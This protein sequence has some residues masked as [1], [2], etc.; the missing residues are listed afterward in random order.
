MRMRRPG[1]SDPE[2]FDPHELEIARSVAADAAGQIAE[3]IWRV[4]ASHQDS[5]ITGLVN[6]VN[7][8][9]CMIAL[10]RCAVP[11]IA[12]STDCFGWN[13]A[14][15]WFCDETR[16]SVERYMDAQESK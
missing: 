9:A 11:L 4:M 12:A 16:A 7:A 13:E 3:Q 10:Q 1:R 14:I 5:P 8:V 2:K 15:D 6:G